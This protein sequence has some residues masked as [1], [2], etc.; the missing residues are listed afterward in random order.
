VK[1]TAL[2]LGEHPALN[3]RWEGEHI[4][5]FRAVHMG[6]A[7]DTEAGLLVPVVRDA[8]EST[9]RQI[10]ARTR[11]LLA[12]ARRRQLRAE[13]MQGGTFTISNLGPFGI[14]AFTPI[15]QYPQCAVLGIGRIRSEPVVRDDRVVPGERLTLSLTFDHRIVDGA[16]AARFLQSLGHLIEN[17]APRLMP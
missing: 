16:P 13:E 17:P 10:A 14:D 4:I 8:V 1:L 7:V 2:A 15:I 6:I 5:E 9:L 12:R 11:D 3:S